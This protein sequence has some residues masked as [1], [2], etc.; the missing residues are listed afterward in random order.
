M[1]RTRGTT[2]VSMAI[3]FAEKWRLDSAARK[4]GTNRNRFIRDWLATLPEPDEKEEQEE[5]P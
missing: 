3:S 4:A 1:V 5:Q 2:F